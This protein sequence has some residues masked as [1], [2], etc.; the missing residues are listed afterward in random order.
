MDEKNREFNEENTG[1]AAYT[2]HIEEC[3]KARKNKKRSAGIKVTAAVLTAALVSGMSVYA[4]C[5]NNTNTTS[6]S[7]ATWNNSVAATASL[8]SETTI[9]DGS[10]EG[11]VAD[12]AA[13]AI[14]SLVTISCTSVEQMRSIFGGSQEYQVSS[15]GSGVIIG[16]DDEALYIATNNH[17]IDDATTVSVGFVDETAAEATVRGA[18]SANDLA[19]V[20]VQLSE[21]SDETLDAI[22]V[23]MIGDSDDLVL[24]DQVVAIGNALGYGQSVTSGYV[25]AFNRTLTLSDG[26]GGTVSSTGLIQ[27]DA[28]IN[29]GN[30]GGG[31]FNMKGELIAINE[32]KSS[33]SSSG[34][35]VDNM[36]FAI[37]MA[38]A[39]PILQAMIDGEDYED[40][41]ASTG[42]SAYLGVSVAEVT[43]EVSS[44][45]NMP[46][47][48]YV[49]SVAKGT[50][51]DKAGIQQGDIITAMDGTQ[52][53]SFEELS[54]AIGAKEPGDS[55]T[56]TISR[57]ANG[58]YE[59]MQIEA[60]LGSTQA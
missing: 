48:V 13:T 1:Y 9:L 15:A 53:T 57:A 31:L 30:S 2:E 11:T 32:A 10:K 40:S 14:S 60:V 42:N 20:E 36:G 5:R 8:T 52:V 23:A 16:M 45:Y 24:G 7:A 17:V 34:V 35:T 39:I 43:E 38:K 29:S 49:S 3:R 50:A 21:L 28:S 33:T 22:S 56:I 59:E 6:A 19:V 27:T 41:S 12:V 46:V 18:D 4:V 25:S 44:M 51:A 55:V 58:E 54:A 47:G 37:P 26:N